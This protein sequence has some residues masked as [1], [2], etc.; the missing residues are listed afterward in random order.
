MAESFFTL[1]FIVSETPLISR[2]GSKG[3]VVKFLTLT[4]ISKGMVTYLSRPI[5]YIDSKA[6]YMKSFLLQQD[7]HIKTIFMKYQIFSCGTSLA[8]NFCLTSN[9]PKFCQLISSLSRCD[10]FLDS[11]AMSKVRSGLSMLFYPCVFGKLAWG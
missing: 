10:K 8:R 9:A 1:C 4:L 2:K 7:S 3:L 6:K 11:S 5:W